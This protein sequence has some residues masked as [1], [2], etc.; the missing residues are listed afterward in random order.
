MAARFKKNR[1]YRNRKR[2]RALRAKFGNLSK[3]EL[4]ALRV[5]EVNTPKDK[6]K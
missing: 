1:K 4:E 5:K 2:L 3:K 6:A